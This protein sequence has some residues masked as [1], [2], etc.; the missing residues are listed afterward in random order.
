MR[1]KPERKR[2]ISA[3]ARQR[4]ARKSHFLAKGHLEK[5]RGKIQLGSGFKSSLVFAAVVLGLVNLAAA[6]ERP[7]LG[8]VAVVEVLLPDRDA[9]DD[10]IRQGYNI[11]NVRGNLAT[12]YATAKEL[13]QL[14]QA[15]YNYR[16]IERQ[17][18]PKEFAPTGLGSYHN[19]AALTSELQDYADAYPDICRLYTLGQS[20]Q[21]CCK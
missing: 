7:R 11:S 21:G 9:L 19:Y 4:P 12:V 16:G 10:L 2:V 14:K 18:Q 20:V 5:I 6:V 8:L 1:Q 17:P 3:P 15:G 13:G